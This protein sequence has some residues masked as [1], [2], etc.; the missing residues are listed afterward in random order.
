M[1]S[2][3]VKNIQKNRLYIYTLYPYKSVVI[4]LN[5]G[6]M[7]SEVSR[8]IAYQF[9]TWKTTPESLSNIYSGTNRKV[10]CRKNLTLLRLLALSVYVCSPSTKKIIEGGEVGV[11][12]S[13]DQFHFIDNLNILHSRV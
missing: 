5:P 6:Y 3:I 9:Y 11:T 12:I 8:E 4:Y 13:K 7:I 2:N 10:V 1:S